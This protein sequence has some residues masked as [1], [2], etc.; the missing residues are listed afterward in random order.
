[1]LQA[2][3]KKWWASGGAGMVS[4]VSSDEHRLREIAA[5]AL[6]HPHREPA[7]PRASAS[8]SEAGWRR[9]RWPGRRH[10]TPQVRPSRAATASLR[11]ADRRR[12]EPRERSAHSGA[13]SAC[14]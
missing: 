11:I 2:I 4:F 12:A 7:V 1:L 8:R 6:E 9:A 3:V 13:R 10:R 14:S 5:A